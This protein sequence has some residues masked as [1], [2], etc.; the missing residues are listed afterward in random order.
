MYMFPE[1]YYKLGNDNFLYKEGKKIDN[2]QD[3]INNIEHMKNTVLNSE[4]SKED[5][6]DTIFETVPY[7]CQTYGD[8]TSQIN[9]ITIGTGKK[10]YYI[11]FIKGG[12]NDYY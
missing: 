9:R 7:V 2:I 3:E 11:K 6:S 12:V 4:L 8:Y 5:K 10:I 1:P